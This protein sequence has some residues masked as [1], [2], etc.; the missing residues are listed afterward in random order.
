MNSGVIQGHMLTH[1][2][3]RQDVIDYLET[4]EASK[5][6]KNKLYAYWKGCQIRKTINN[7][8]RIRR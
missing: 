1:C 2:E 6:Q 7:Q 5:E 3:T 8:M 4:I